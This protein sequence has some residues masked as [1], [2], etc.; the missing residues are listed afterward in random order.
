M[1]YFLLEV[2]Y[3]AS[4]TTYRTHTCANVVYDLLLMLVYMCDSVYDVY[5]YSVLLSRLHFLF[6]GSI[7]RIYRYGFGIIYNHACTTYK[8]CMYKNTPTH[9]LNKHSHILQHMH[10]RSAVRH[11]YIYTH[12]HIHIFANSHI[13]TYSHVHSLT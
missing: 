10:R 8:S 3:S 4:N 11:T 1:W 2:Y 12:P 13:F 9:T 6:S 7:A 5:I